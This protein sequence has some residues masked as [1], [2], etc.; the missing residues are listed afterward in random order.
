LPATLGGARA[1]GLPTAWRFERRNAGDIA[2]VSLDSIG[3]QTHHDPADALIFFVRQAG[4]VLATVRWEESY[5]NGH[6]TTTAEMIFDANGITNSKETRQR[7]VAQN[8]FSIT[9]VFC[10]MTTL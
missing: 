6:M 2:V 9:L 10:I 8:R 7:G 5:R 4:N 3:Q 1:L